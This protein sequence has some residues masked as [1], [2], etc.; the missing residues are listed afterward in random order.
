MI[1]IDDVAST[2]GVSRATVSRHLNGKHVRAH[3]AVSAAIAETGFSLNQ[4]ARSLKSGVTRSI[5]V[6][7]PDIANPYFAQAVRGI[8]VSSR[9]ERYNIFLCNTDESSARQE[10]VL[11]GLVGRVDALI[12]APATESDAVPKALGVMR[13]PVVLLDREFAD[14]S[15]YDSVLVDNEGGAESAVRYLAQLG[16]RRI[17]FISGPLTATPG[18]T[19]HEGYMRG[20]RA[21]GI[22]PRADDICIGD[23][24]E[25]SGYIGAKSLLGLPD[26]P[27]AIFA[28]NNLMAIGALKALRESNRRV[29]DDVSFISFDELEVGELLEPRLTTVTRPTTEQGALAATLL[30]ERLRGEAPATARR[31]VLE[32][33]LSVR[34][35]CSPPSFARAEGG[36]SCAS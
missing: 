5:G 23:F 3:A 30:A 4:I 22:L 29:P 19:R 31:C 6:V 11:E 16:H 26:P 9:D 18:R 12:L 33:R 32:T 8:E 35:S 2:A 17:G 13:V 27:T 20:L 34:E 24:R 15:L 1:T 28:A 10:E 7:V 25:R 21:A 14:H 36:V